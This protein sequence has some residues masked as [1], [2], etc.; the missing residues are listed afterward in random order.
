MAEILHF[1]RADGIKLAYRL[2]DGTGPLL[3]FLPG[4][5]SDMARAK[6]TAMPDCAS[7]KG[8]PGLLHHYSG[9]G[10]GE[11]SVSSPALT[12]RGGH[13]LAGG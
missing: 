12:G 13:C 3:V 9:C 4:Y 6:A 1:T 11:G 8:R 7:A 10:R 2:V 5:M